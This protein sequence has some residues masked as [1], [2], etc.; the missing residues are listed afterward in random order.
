MMIQPLS[1]RAGGR[2]RITEQASLQQLATH[3]VL[4]L[5]IAHATIGLHEQPDTGYSCDNDNDENTL[6]Q[7]IL[8]F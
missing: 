7:R 6:L 8:F 4:D 5:Y 3:V 1:Y 2:L